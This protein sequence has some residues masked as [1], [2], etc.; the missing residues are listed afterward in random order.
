[1]KNVNLL[2]KP[3]SSLCNL[4]CEYCFYEDEAQNRTQRSMG[5]MKEELADELIR[6][7]FEAV[8]PDGAVSF[9]FQGGEP[10]VA[11]LPFFRHFAEKVKQYRPPRVRI[12]FAI[13]TNGTLLNED[14]AQFL[15]A[16]GFL[17]GL[18]VDGFREAHEAHRVDAE[19]NGTWKRVLTA[20]A[21][22]DQYA[23]DYNALCVVTGHCARHPEKAYGSLKNLGFRYIQFI[24]CLDPIGHDR[25]QEPWSL[26]PER[27]G[28][29]LC[30]VFDL[31]YR[32]WVQ[33]NYHSI[34]LFEDYVHVL[35]GD[36]ASTCSTCGK[37]GSYLVLEGDGSAYPCD[38]FVLDHWKIGSIG[39]M[40]I[41]DMAASEKTAAFLHWGSVKPVE[42]AAC[43]Y[44]TLC[45]GGCKND[46]YTDETGSHNY[47]CASFRELLDHALPRLQQIARAE[48]AAKRQLRL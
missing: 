14:W 21:L 29:F 30:R 4:R 17:V 13:Q 5:V 31:W 35:L 20:K 33:G 2:I 8:D 26:T 45:N 27:Y 25:G 47:F 10:T 12:S 15:K 36:G 43:P 28:R 16:E 24:A 41:A 32:D 37:C 48:L 3:A 7:V 9:A 19:G 23:V 22:L 11:G 1:M 38:F 46:W 39:E 44:R 42:C 6:Q 40:T 18:S 34:R